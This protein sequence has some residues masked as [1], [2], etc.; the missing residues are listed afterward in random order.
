MKN[1]RGL[2]TWRDPF[3]ARDCAEKSLFLLLLNELYPDEIDSHY[4]FAG[5]STGVNQCL[6][7]K[8]SASR[9]LSA[10]TVLSVAHPTYHPPAL[11]VKESLTQ[12]GGDLDNMFFF[13]PL[14]EIPLFPG[15]HDKFV[16]RIESLLQSDDGLIYEEELILALFRLVGGEHP[17]VKRFISEKRG[18]L[19]EPHGRGLLPII[20]PKLRNHMFVIQE[21]SRVLPASYC[22]A[23]QVLNNIQEKRY[24]GGA[25]A[26][27]VKFV[28]MSG[29]VPLQEQEALLNDASVSLSSE[30]RG[31]FRKLIAFRKSL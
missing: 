28:I 6:L 10:L 9:F 5:V 30:V 27:A 20:F 21:L 23:P 31:R 17:R 18:A 25:L 13:E 24:T 16:R 2:N 3:E 1:F 12:K 11:E 7:D 26:E 8:N 19:R 29:F 15:K 22:M 14:L 4:P